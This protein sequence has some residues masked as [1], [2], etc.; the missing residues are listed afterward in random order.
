MKNN[1]FPLMAIIFLAVGVLACQE[2]EDARGL[3]APDSTP[4]G[5]VSEIAVTN[6]PGGAKIEYKL[7]DDQDAL[8]VEAS[9]RLGNGE[10]A[11]AKSSIFKNFVTIEGLRQ[12]E[13]Q[14]VSLVV[15]DR[16][17]HRS[18]PVVVSIS[19]ETAPID[20]L[21]ATFELEPDF[22]GVR[23]KYNNEDEIR[24]EFL[25]YTI[26][27]GQRVYQQSA[28]IDGNQANFYIFRGF[29]STTT[30]LGIEAVDRWDNIS[31]LLVVDDILPLEEVQLDREDM[32]GK[33]LTGDQPDAWGWVISNLFNG[34][35]DSPGFTTPQD[36][37]G[38]IIPPY[39][40]PN[41]VFTIDM[42]VMAKLSRFKMFPRMLP[43]PTCC[44]PYAHG[45]PRFFELWGIDEIPADNGT[46]LEGWTRLVENG[47]VIKPSG[48]PLGTTSPEDLAQAA[49]GL[50]FT[51]PIEAPP[52]RFIRFVNFENWA[53]A[54]FVTVM[55]LEFFGQIEE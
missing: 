29:P 33:F 11:T 34:T 44:G 18:P 40:E 19:P 39:T 15:V 45:D 4:P 53:G 47:E 49:A 32:E 14:E 51:L 20:K 54:K 38:N 16:S 22:G 23:L 37:Q 41:H 5:I 55:E 6:L 36:T 1:I 10:T 50:E 12:A 46:S 31:E 26:E 27:N 30:T 48:A 43:G 8:L 35:N 2:E 7:P 42:G 21:F 9:Y 25:L 24:V 17:N 52:V 3:A 13:S 28:F